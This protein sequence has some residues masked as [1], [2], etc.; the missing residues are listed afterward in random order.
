MR[1]HFRLLGIV[2]L[3]ICASGCALFQTR[4]VVIDRQSDVVRLGKG[5]RGEI[6][7]QQAD[8]SWVKQ[9]KVTLPEGW[10]AGPGP[11]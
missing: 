9:G 2:G 10:Y 5:V 11:K 7:T 6:Y 3:L 1:T 8:G 4:T